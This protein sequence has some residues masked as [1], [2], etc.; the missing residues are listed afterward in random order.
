MR[1]LP[2]LFT[3]VLHFAIRLFSHDNFPSSG[4]SI[5][6]QESVLLGLR[7]RY[8]HC[9]EDERCRIPYCILSHE[10]LSY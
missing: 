1:T 10:E 2:V 8:K 5:K 9:Q 3:N 7:V 6:F 4:D